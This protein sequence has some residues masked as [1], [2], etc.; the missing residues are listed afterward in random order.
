MNVDANSLVELKV[1]N[2]SADETVQFFRTS[3][4]LSQDEEYWMVPIHGWV[5]QSPNSVIRNAALTKAFEKKYDLIESQVLSRYPHR[6]F[7]LAVDSGEHDAEV[8]ASIAQK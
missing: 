8:Y 1:W 6:R 7:I 2:V 4:W 5:Y 3:A